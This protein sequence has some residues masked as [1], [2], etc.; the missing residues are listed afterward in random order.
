MQVAARAGSVPGVSCCKFHCELSPSSPQKVHGSTERASVTLC[1]S[2]WGLCLGYIHSRL[3]RQGLRDPLL[4]GS[5]SSL[6]ATA[7]L[8]DLV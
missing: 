6:I 8:T 7:V 2:P 5:L 3:P 1:L 4:F